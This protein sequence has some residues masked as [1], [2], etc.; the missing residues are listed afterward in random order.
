MEM[1]TIRSI[2]YTMVALTLIIL[3]CK[4][5]KNLKKYF[6]FQRTKFCEGKCI[7][8]WNNNEYIFF[9]QGNFKIN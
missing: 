5:A 3:F 9:Q 4:N 8:F 1:Y 7:R 2:L 6:D